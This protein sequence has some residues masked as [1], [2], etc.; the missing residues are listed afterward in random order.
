MGR[1]LAPRVGTA[2]AEGLRIEAGVAELTMPGVNR[3]PGRRR[4]EQ[5]PL[6]GSS[7]VSLQWLHTTPSSMQSMHMVASST[8][9]ARLQVSQPAP[10]PF[11]TP[12]RVALPAPQIRYSPE[13]AIDHIAM[14][15]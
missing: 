2:H 5:Q 12:L 3:S 8:H 13:S 11:S 6:V 9:Y 1:G 15:A 14:R 4:I 10:A 7:N